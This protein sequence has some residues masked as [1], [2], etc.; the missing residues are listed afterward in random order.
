MAPLISFP[1]LM[2]PADK[3]N[4]SPPLLMTEFRSMPPA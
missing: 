3:M 1:P 4:D 2:V